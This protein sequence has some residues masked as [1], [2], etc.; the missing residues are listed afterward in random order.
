MT[1]SWTWTAKDKAEAVPSIGDQYI[2]MDENVLCLRNPMPADSAFMAKMFSATIVI[3]LLLWVWM[4]CAVINDTPSAEVWV[5]SFPCS[6]RW[7]FRCS[8]F[9]EST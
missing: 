9:T 1:I 7:A 8:F 4:F 2:S 5:L 6:C 3:T